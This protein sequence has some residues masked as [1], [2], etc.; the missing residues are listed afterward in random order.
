M[1][2]SDSSCTVPAAL[3]WFNTSVGRITLGPRPQQQD[4]PGL[5][6]AQV[7]HIVSLQTSTEDSKALEKLL[8]KSNIQWR[9]MPIEISRPSKA[10]DVAMLQQY[11]NETQKLLASGASIYVHC[12]DSANRCSLFLYALLHHLRL[13]SSSAYSALYSL[14]CS[15]VH[16]IARNDL[17]WAADLGASVKHQF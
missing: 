4:L 1:T 9:W 17:A 16:T 3:S 10:A 5:E 11:L 13:P 8:N 15:A 12:N 7:S 6:Q 2:E 14:Q